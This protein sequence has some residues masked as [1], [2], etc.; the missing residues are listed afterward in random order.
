MGFFF[1]IGFRSL[2]VSLSCFLFSVSVSVSAQLCS[3]VVDIPSLLAIVP[4]PVSQNP[5]FAKFVLS[6]LVFPRNRK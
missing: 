2:S 6:S 1:C 5:S 4:L 3:P